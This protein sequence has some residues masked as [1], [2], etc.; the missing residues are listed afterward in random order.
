MR[1]LVD[2]NLSPRVCDHLNRAG[3]EAVHVRD[4]GL[5][6]APDSQVLARAAADGRILLTADRGD[7]GRELAHTQALEPSVILLRQLPDIV[8]AD[9]IAALLLLN[10]TPALAAALAKGAFVVFAAS[11]VRLRYLPLR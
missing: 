1:F 5:R 8:R 11:A 4:E 6:G 2:E 9:E 10:L 7:F 3:H